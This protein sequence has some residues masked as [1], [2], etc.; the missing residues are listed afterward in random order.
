MSGRFRWQRQKTAG[1]FYPADVQ[2]SIRAVDNQRCIIERLA[3]KYAKRYELVV[4]LPI[5]MEGRDRATVR[6]GIDFGPRLCADCFGDAAASLNLNPHLI[7]PLLCERSGCN[8][9]R[10]MRPGFQTSL[11]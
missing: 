8:A 4:A 2:I 6:R 11:G 9:M 1:D 5:R 7:G 10:S 3:S